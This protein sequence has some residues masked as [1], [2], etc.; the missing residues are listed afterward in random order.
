MDP[1]SL[2]T[3]RRYAY[4]FFFLFV[5]ILPVAVMY[6]SGY[7]LDGLSLVPTGGIYV[8]VPVSG[9]AISLNGEVRGRSSLFSRSF[10]FDDLASDSY[11]V[12][13]EGEGYY[14]WTKAVFVEPQLVSDVGVLMV[15]QPLTV[16]ELTLK[17]AATSTL[18]SVTIEE[19]TTIREVF[20][21]TSTPDTDA[22]ASLVVERGNLYITWSGRSEPPSSFCLR[23]SLCTTR[24]AL[25]QGD[26]MVTR[27]EF[28]QGG[29]LYQTLESG[30][31]FTEID[32]RTPRLVVP[33]FGT[34]GATF[35]IIDGALIVEDDD[36]YFKV[37]G[38]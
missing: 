3:R 26:E 9:V 18:R 8:S 36:T 35:R 7:R 33:V 28:Y 4:T 14:P 38:L 29:A 15:E 27:A 17:A 22:D 13:A 20:A 5:A 2:K 25:E 11:V 32:I 6:A 16:Q 23:P 30:V 19:L 21:A 10:F 24:F 1:L 31:H 34:P 12:S 37:S